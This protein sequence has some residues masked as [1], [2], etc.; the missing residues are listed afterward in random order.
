MAHS[1]RGLYRL[2]LTD[3]RYDETTGIDFEERIERERRKDRDRGARRDV[4][5]RRVALIAMRSS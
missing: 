3:R 5:P 1:V 2:K 4:M